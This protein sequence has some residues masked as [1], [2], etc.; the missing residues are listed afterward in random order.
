MTVFE[1]VLDKS[2]S[3]CCSFGKNC[4]CSLNRVR[5]LEVPSS[6]ANANLRAVRTLLL[7]HSQ[8]LKFCVT[9]FLL[10]CIRPYLTFSVKRNSQAGMFEQVCD[11]GSFFTDAGQ[12]P[13]F[14]IFLTSYF[15][16][17]VAGY[18]TSLWALWNGHCSIECSA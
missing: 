12:T 17:I 11:A 2:R 3:Y 8:I 15:V 10:F 9:D 4:K 18:T 7:I 6:L 1:E 16:S 5:K 13:F 14:R